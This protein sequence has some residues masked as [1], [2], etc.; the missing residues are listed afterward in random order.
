M[1]STDHQAHPACAGLLA[2]WLK[3]LLLPALLLMYA[4]PVSAANSI[5]VLENVSDFNVEMDFS[6]DGQM[7]AVTEL[8]GLRVYDLASGAIVFE[9][10]F[11]ESSSDVA[12]GADGQHV[13]VG[14]GEAGGA[15][16]DISDLK[17]P[18]KRRLDGKW[19]Q[20]SISQD[21]KLVTAWYRW[22]SEHDVLAASWEG[23]EFPPYDYSQHFPSIIFDQKG[24]TNLHLR[25][26]AFSF[27]DQNLFMVD[28]Q[29][30]A[31]SG[32]ASTAFVIY[33]RPATKDNLVGY[34]DI[35]KSKNIRFL[36][37]K[38]VEEPRL[39]D[40][41]ET[42]LGPRALVWLVEGSRE[43]LAG[44]DPQTDTVHFSLDVPAGQYERFSGAAISSDGLRVAVLRKD[45]AVE[46]FATDDAAEPE[47][48]ISNSDKTK[49]PEL[50]LTQGHGDQISAIAI[51]PDGTLLATAGADDR[52]HI[53]DAANGRQ[54]RSIAEGDLTW[55]IAFS[56]DSK[57]ILSVG[58][59]VNI[60]RIA[61]GKRI[62]T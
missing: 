7:L 55:Q 61:D 28:G 10:K 15:I 11:E 2:K 14:F 34:F 32:P 56:P 4:S 59:G 25:Q 31:T 49:Q 24:N 30:A 47:K 20:L 27:A 12:F 23:V 3:C 62:Y 54:L 42:S 52:T 41:R 37:L 48:L 38:D 60:W 40:F 43:R 45:H 16:I 50:A 18:V 21:G 35:T 51:S 33:N 1:K 58:D 17:E 22:S 44:Y 6:P 29:T 5:A 9:T 39:V 19:D 46:I 36:T 53:W 26:L 8:S 57:F 13:V